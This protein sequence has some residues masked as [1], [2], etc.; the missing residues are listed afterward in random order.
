MDSVY[1]A[2]LSRQWRKAKHKVVETLHVAGWRPSMP[3]RPGGVLLADDGEWVGVGTLTLPRSE[4]AA[5]IGLIERY[6]QRHS[7]GT[8]TI[9]P[10]CIQ[11]V[12]YYTS[13][14]SPLAE[15]RGFRSLKVALG[16]CPVNEVSRVVS[17][18]SGVGR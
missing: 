5:L 14:M 3:G 16:S 9:P 13:R 6:G 1:R 12:V 10:D 2:G 7:S 11:A 18:L 8:V 4:R 15:T 17:G